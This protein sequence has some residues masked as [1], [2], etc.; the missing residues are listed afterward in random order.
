MFHLLQVEPSPE[1]TAELLP[2][3]CRL[4][5]GENG[6]CFNLQSD[7]K[8][9]S[10]FVRSVDPNSPAER[11]GLRTGDRIVEVQLT[12]VPIKKEGLKVLYWRK[13]IF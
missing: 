4:V 10:Q 12:D 9:G 6:Y 2:R 5:K 11:A 13:N 8:K 7:K 1:P 3:L